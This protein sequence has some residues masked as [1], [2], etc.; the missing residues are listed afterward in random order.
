MAR[1]AQKI[2]TFMVK[3]L[4][5]CRGASWLRLRGWIALLI[6]VLL[7]VLFFVVR[8]GLEFGQG[9]RAGVRR[10]LIVFAL[11]R[12]IMAIPKHYVEPMVLPEQLSTLYPLDDSGWGMVP[13][14]ARIRSLGYGGRLVGG[15]AWQGQL[16][17]IAAHMLQEVFRS[18]A[19][20]SAWLPPRPSS[21]T[22][23]F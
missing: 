23:R 1:W 4:Y 11:P 17:R 16:T 6:Q 7:P 5:F 22:R 18:A 9:V 12:Q 10:G 19:C 8:R 13:S 20:K 3:A 15:D 21:T 2:F 14:G